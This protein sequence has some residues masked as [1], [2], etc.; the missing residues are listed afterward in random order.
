VSRRADAFTLAC[1]LAGALVVLFVVSPL[2]ATLLGSTPARLA[3]TAGDTEVLR[4]LAV[5]FA[6]GLLATAIG[7]VGGVPLAYLLARRRF[8]GRRAIEGLVMLPVVV[9]H[10]AA[11]VALL[12]VYGRR[13]LLGQLLAPLGLTFTDTIAGVTVA[14]LFVGLPFL[15]SASRE[16]F[17][18][19]DAEIERVALTD[20]A[21]RWQAFYLIALPAAGRG[22]L[23]GA[24]MMWSRGI[25]EFGAVAIIAY[26]PRILPVLIYEFFT[27]YGLSAALPL[28]AVLIIVVLA[29]FVALQALLPRA[30]D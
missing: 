28:A 20:G 15:V 14:M 13:G 8:R 22:I 29:V 25:S 6:A 12:L 17:A 3:E 4:S 2:A 30:E 5:T 24:V 21:T 26:H 9:P 23:S 1:V 19:V 10:T 7:A 27:G 11:G 16:A 18:L